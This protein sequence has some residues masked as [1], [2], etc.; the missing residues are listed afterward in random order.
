MVLSVTMDE[1]AVCV[2]PRFA[3]LESRFDDCGFSYLNAV[4]AS[5]LTTLTLLE[6]LAANLLPLSRM[7]DAVAVFW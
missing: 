4:V 3:C 7:S 6:A 2:V 5:P 1:V